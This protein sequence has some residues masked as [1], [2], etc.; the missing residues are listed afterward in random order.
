MD[1]I[2][3]NRIKY[4]SGLLI[5]LFS[6][7][8]LFAQ[9]E[10]SI[11]SFFAAGHTYGSPA[12]PQFGLHPPFVDYI[13]NINNYT[14]MDLG[15]LT[16]DVVVQG[17]AEYWDAAQSD[18]ESFNFPIHIAAGNHDMGPEFLNRFGDYYYSFIH[19]DDLFIILTPGLDS[20]NISDSQLEFLTNTLD[21]NYAAVNNVFIFLHELIWWS[22]DNEYQN[23]HI[24]YVPYYPGYTNFDDVV[25]PLLLSY[26]NHFTLYAGDVGSSD[27]GTPFMYHS[28]DNITLIAS[29]MGG[30]VRDNIIVTEVYEDSVYYNLVAINGDNPMALGEL[31]DF[32]LNN[33]QTVGLA[34]GLFL[35]PNP[36]KSFFNV[37]FIQ[38]INTSPEFELWDA[39][40]R[41]ISILSAPTS[42]VNGCFHFNS[43]ELDGISQGYYFLM[44]NADGKLTSIPIIKY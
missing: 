12:N 19:Q 35:Y 32:T 33:L 41:R 21:S 39:Y 37:Q 11:Y 9:D 34:Q 4:L 3:N 2:I 13:P 7:G 25:K 8:S 22:P 43:T 26:P 29:G 44:V 36:F 31:T 27:L 10:E 15:I 6:V 17:S 14:N 5:L 16:G 28:F 42:T 18:I 40:G 30:G 23:V 38:P 1:D 24:N 20:W